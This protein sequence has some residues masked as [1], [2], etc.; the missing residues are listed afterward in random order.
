[1]GN[2]LFAV[3]I[4]NVSVSAI[5]M[6]LNTL[7]NVYVKNGVLTGLLLNIPNTTHACPFYIY[8]THMNNMTV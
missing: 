3:N 1:M 4:Q 7:S 8:I 2:S 5:W 6:R